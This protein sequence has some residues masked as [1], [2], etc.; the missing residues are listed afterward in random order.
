MGLH[1][2]I[3]FLS[4]LGLP[5]CIFLLRFIRS[6][7]KL[8][9]ICIYFLFSLYLFSFL[10]F[11]LSF[12][13]LFIFNIL[14]LLF[15]YLISLFVMDLS[16]QEYIWLLLSFNFCGRN[17]WILPKCIEHYFQLLSFVLYIYVLLWSILYLTSE[18]LSLQTTFE[19]EQVRLCKTV[20]N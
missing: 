19:T 6:F 1:W 4:S 3:C 14:L 17:V 11:F 7:T 5:L 13:F 8:F 2:R 15:L 9:F 16:A 18:L 12:C 20:K 10:C